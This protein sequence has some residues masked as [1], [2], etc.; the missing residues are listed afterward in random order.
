MKEVAVVERARNCQLVE[1]EHQRPA[2]RG[3]EGAVKT[4][5]K[6]KGVGVWEGIACVGG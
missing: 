3:G 4:I 5:K 6:G 2:P 1:L